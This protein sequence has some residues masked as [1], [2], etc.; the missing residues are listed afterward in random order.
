MLGRF[1]DDYDRFGSFYGSVPSFGLGGFPGGTF[2]NYGLSDKYGGRMDRLYSGWRSGGVGM[3]NG[4]SSFRGRPS[5]PQVVASR[6]PLIKPPM[7]PSTMP[8]TPSMPLATSVPVAAPM[9]IDPLAASVPVAAPMAID[10]LAAS[11]ALP[12][13]LSSPVQEIVPSVVPSSVVPFAQSVAP[14]QTLSP[15]SQSVVLPAQTQSVVLPS[16]T[17]GGAYIV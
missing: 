12:V 7:V 1:Y 11:G 5:V 3:I 17:V 2:G 13:S 4:A 16:S 10:P 15:V 8:I 14:I 9:A 6:P